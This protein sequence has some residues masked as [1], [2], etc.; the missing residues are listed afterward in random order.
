M[1]LVINLVVGC[2]CF[3][4]GQR[5]PSQCPATVYAT[6]IKGSWTIPTVVND[7]RPY[8][9]T[10]QGKLLYGA[11]AWFGFCTA[12][13]SSADLWN[14]DTHYSE[15]NLTFEE[16]CAEADEQLFNRLIYDKNHVLHRCWGLYYL[17]QQRHK[18]TTF[19]N[20]GIQFNYLNTTLVL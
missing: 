4:P 9:A 16:V 11:S 18:A 17:P 3:L 5:L 1:T 14:S 2:S 15:R 7:V 12:T 13:C 8:R 10:V 20:E 19:E 6:C